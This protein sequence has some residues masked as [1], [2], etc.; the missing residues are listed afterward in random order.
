MRK[1]RTRQHRIGTIGTRVGADFGI[2]RQNPASDVSAIDTH[3]HY[4]TR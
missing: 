4:A 2:R 1:G 3:Q